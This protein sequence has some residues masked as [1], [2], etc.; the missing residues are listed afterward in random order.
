MG[1]F[2]GTWEPQN[3]VYI[4][5]RQN[6]NTPD[7]KHEVNGRN[8]DGQDVIDLNANPNTF[9]IDAGNTR[10]WLMVLWDADD[11]THMYECVL[12]GW[13]RQQHWH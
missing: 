3:E 7:G 12:F 9:V 2:T 8:Y 11:I 4:Y 10:R 6:Q 5:S 1:E 13:L